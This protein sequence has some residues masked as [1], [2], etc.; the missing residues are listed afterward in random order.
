MKNCGEFERL[1][2]IINGLEYILQRSPN[3]TGTIIKKKK[4]LRLYYHKPYDVFS[5][6]NYY[7]LW[8]FDGQTVVLTDIYVID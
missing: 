3:S 6:K 2:E 1:E 7:I 5:K 8:S 4:N